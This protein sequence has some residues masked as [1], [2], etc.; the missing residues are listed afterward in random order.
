MRLIEI[1]EAVRM[2]SNTTLAA[3]ICS[4]LLAELDR[5]TARPASPCGMA[6]HAQDCECEGAGGDR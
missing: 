3:I 2:F 1:R 5:H 6:H 4:E